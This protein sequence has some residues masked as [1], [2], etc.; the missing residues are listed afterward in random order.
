MR[1]LKLT[2]VL[3]ALS[4]L[5]I[6]GCAG[7]HVA[8][9]GRRF[10]G[11]IET[12]SVPMFVNRTSKARAE[13]FLT[14]PFANEL[15]KAGSV[16]VVGRGEGILKGTVQEYTVTSLS[17]DSQDIVKKYRLTVVIDLVLVESSSEKVLWEGRGLRDSEDFQAPQDVI[18][19]T[20]EH[21]ALKKVAV[22]LARLFK[23]RALEDF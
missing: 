11:G 7:Y 12:V 21:A 20:N 10:P 4:L 16:K 17:Y 14:V 15:A 13:S 6:F 9:K 23:E 22:D 2:R 8:G 1:G 5:F 19:E 3:L 18:S